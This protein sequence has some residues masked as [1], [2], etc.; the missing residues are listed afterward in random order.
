MAPLAC[1]CRLPLPPPSRGYRP[2]KRAAALP[3]LP[4]QHALALLAS[5]RQ[6]AAASCPITVAT[7]LVSLAGEPPWLLLQRRRQVPV[8]PKLKARAPAF[9]LSALFAAAPPAV[10]Y[11]S[12]AAPG[13]T[14]CRLPIA[15]PRRVRRRSPRDR[16]AFAAWPRVHLASRRPHAG[17]RPEPGEH[18][19]ALV[20]VRLLCADCDHPVGLAGCRPPASPL[21]APAVLLRGSPSPPAAFQRRLAAAARPGCDRSAFPHEPAPLPHF[22]LSRASSGR[23]LRVRLLAPPSAMPGAPWPAPSPPLM[24]PAAHAGAGKEKELSRLPTAGL[25]KKKENVVVPRDVAL[26]SVCRACLASCPSASTPGRLEGPSGCPSACFATRIASRD[27]PCQTPPPARDAAP[28][29]AQPARSSARPTVPSRPGGRSAS[30]PNWSGPIGRDP[31]LSIRRLEGYPQRTNL[32]FLHDNLR[33]EPL[34][35]RRLGGWLQ[36]RHRLQLAFPAASATSTAKTLRPT[37]RVARR[38]HPVGALAR[39]PL[40]AICA[41]CSPQPAVIDNTSR[42]TSRL[43]PTT[44]VGGLRVYA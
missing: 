41:G 3:P 10:R 1:A 16:L 13:P 36:A 39:P 40:E 44:P 24:W 43:R 6:A 32:V 20:R 28:T 17:Y 34:L 5:P 27:P 37:L 14:V 11:I 8:A 29:T 30:T 4:V 42:R 19:V 21:P 33:G 35:A 7:R 38:L 18:P 12:R 26:P 31:P 22:A 9:S 23:R 15:S 25:E 2:V